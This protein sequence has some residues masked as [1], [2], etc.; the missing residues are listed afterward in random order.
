MASFHRL[1]DL[2]ICESIPLQPRLELGLMLVVEEGRRLKGRHT[3][4][5]RRDTLRP[6]HS[7]NC[8]KRRAITINCSFH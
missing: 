6:I 5:K 2:S 1:I 3:G 8:R 4:G 7:R